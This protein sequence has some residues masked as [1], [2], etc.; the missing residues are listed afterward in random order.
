MLRLARVSRAFGD[1]V[2]VTVLE[3]L[4]L[5][6][7]QGEYVAIQGPSG[8]G[9]S[10]LLNILGVLDRPDE[11][12]YEVDG[13]PTDASSDS[14]AAQLRSDVFGFVFQQF[15]LLD[16]RPALDSVE[17]AL[18]YRG[19]AADERRSRAA[20]AL[21]NVGLER[22]A[23]QMPKTMSG[24]ERQRVAIARAIASETPVLLADEPT[25]N[26]DSGSGARVVEALESAWRRGVTLVVVTHDAD[27]AKRAERQISLRDGRVIADTGRPATRAVQPAPAPPGRA[28]V[29]RAR[30]LTQDVIRGATAARGRS[31][32]VAA[33]VAVAVALVIATVGIAQ[34]AGAQVSSAFDALVNREV[35]IEAQQPGQPFGGIEDEEMIARANQVAGISNLGILTDAGGHEFRAGVARPTYTAR[36]MAITGDVVGATRL[37]ISWA[38][39]HEPELLQGETLLGKDLAASLEIGSLD[40]RPVV[41]IDGQSSTVAGIITSSPRVPDIMGS[42]I[43]PR[44]DLVA[45]AQTVTVVARTA[46]GAAEQVAVYLP[47]ALYPAQPETS[48][49]HAPPT[50]DTLRGSIEESAQVTLIALSVVVSGAATVSIAAVKILAVNQRRREI[51]IRRAMGARMRHIAALIAAEA[52]VLG[53]LGGVFGLVIGMLAILALTASQGWA[54]VFD[55]RLAPAAVVMG[56]VMGVIG[57]LAAMIAARRVQPQ[58]ALRE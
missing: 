21:K 37:D 15:H 58:Q 45:P 25:G 52:T 14:K 40:R 35:A 11:G 10:T 31:A 20:D 44:G 57:G 49:V 24:G 12:Y 19:I 16:S 53:M 2:K 4:D 32:A 42:A 54:P 7:E 50:I 33:V 30:D 18:M 8:C 29:L 3:S 48:A 22:Q 39:G 26:L 46:Q 41:W 1:D 27:V 34:S 6:I 55:F 56:S 47:I 43:I 51:G 13:A 5:E 9:K 23:D 17:M 38:T 36:L 28:S